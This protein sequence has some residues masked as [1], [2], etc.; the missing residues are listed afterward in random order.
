MKTRKTYFAVFHGKIIPCHLI[1]KAHRDERGAYAANSRRSKHRFQ[2]AYKDYET[3]RAKAI[4]Y[5]EKFKPDYGT[6]N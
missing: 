1:D 4:E 2:V 5:W 3:A 6:F